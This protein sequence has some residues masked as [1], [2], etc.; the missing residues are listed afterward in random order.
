[1]ELVCLLHTVNGQHVLY[2]AVIRHRG[3]TDSAVA[4]QKYQRI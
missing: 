4:M 3:R 1:M 2:L